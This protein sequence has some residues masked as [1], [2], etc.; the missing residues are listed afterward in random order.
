MKAAEE[1][2]WLENIDSLKQY[3][4]YLY[5]EL[6]QY[7]G[8]VSELEG[9]KY[10]KEKCAVKYGPEGSF[11]V[12]TLETKDGGT[13][14]NI[15]CEGKPVRMNSLYNQKREAE[16]WAEQFRV[17]KAHQ[18]IICFGL[19]NGVCL[20]ELVSRILPDTVL[21]LIEPEEAMFLKLLQD[22]EYQELWNHKLLQLLVGQSCEEAFHQALSLTV[23]WT[24][25]DALQFI[26]HPQ[27]DIL[28]PEVYKQYYEQY[29]D[30]R[31][32]VVVNHMTE[33]AIGRKMSNNILA[34]LSYCNKGCLIT[35]VAREFDANLPAIIVSAG[36]SL[37]K[38]IFE[39]KNLH[40]NAYI[41]AVDTAVKYL[42][43]QEIYP[44]IIVT[45]DP[46]KSTHHL[47][48]PRCFSIPLFCR[49]EANPLVLKNFEKLVFFNM[50]GYFAALV[51][52][53]GKITDNCNSGGSVTTGA[54]SVC[55][56][57]GFQEIILIGSDLAYLN[58]KTHAGS[59]TV[60]V[61]NTARYMVKVED[62]YGNIVQTRY[63]WYVYLKWLEDAVKRYNTIRV[64]DAT[65]GGARI[66]GT[67]LLTLHEVVEEINEQNH[68]TKR[69]VLIG[70]T[71]VPEIYN[72]IKVD[73][74]TVQSIITRL[75][76]NIKNAKETLKI[77]S[78]GK[79]PRKVLLDRMRDNNSWIE[80]QFIYVL[81]DG[82]IVNET[83]EDVAGLVNDNDSSLTAEIKVFERALNLY[84]AMIKSAESML[85]KLCSLTEGR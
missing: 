5:E 77:M 51:N 63:D 8:G 3:N 38:N 9:Y 31:N 70:E 22:F 69:L 35:E 81:I 50:E 6:K 20:K 45:L 16:R 7:W 49:V 52:R 75:Q 10:L 4:Q 72:I 56:T 40:H 68:V 84:E 12:E 66:H 11:F 54:F 79:S 67:E 30:Y 23:D 42:L 25:V 55:V 17:T 18:V 2:Q 1:K 74:V 82:D 36:P 73:A 39:L 78:K 15:T 21:I 28:F 60:D 44:D 47:N 24:N 13:T 34:N 32:L 29:M 57:L 26:K 53:M 59:L 41:I 71:L 58:D 19:G 48:D 76:E 61:A 43:K 80:S 27:Y 33:R 64:I 46:E 83:S 85:P 37:D 14:Y 62:I 65:E